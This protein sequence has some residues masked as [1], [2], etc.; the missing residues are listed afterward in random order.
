MSDYLALDIGGANIKVADGASYVRSEPF[1]LWKHPENLAGTLARVIA[2]GPDR[3]RIV[4]T[5]TG[6]LADCYA[7]KCE[8]VRAIVTALLEAASGRPTSV[9]RTD[10][11][12]ID[13]DAALED[14]LPCAASNWHALARWAGRFVPS[15]PAMLLDTGST[16]C[17]AIPL[18]DGRVV[19]KGSTD[20]ERLLAGE[21]AYTGVT[22]TPV[23]AAVGAL[24]YRGQMC[25]VAAEWFAT[26]RDAYLWLDEL[27]EMPEC[28]ETADGRP[29]TKSAALDRLARCICADRETF[30]EE[31]A[32]AAAQAVTQA[33]GATIGIAMRRAAAVLGAT[34]ERVVISG[35]GEFLARRVVH[36]LRWPAEVISL[37]EQQ[38]EKISAAGAAHAVAILAGET[39]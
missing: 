2:D 13:A 26:T 1:A 3:P 7:T 25:P 23:C 19:A 5:M 36:Q 35:Q 20:T 38:G 34:P 33:Q 9:Y 12:F 28:T 16:T 39:Q 15:G 10:G 14:P 17:D 31:D 37:S 8:G 21:L 6:E 4:A 22:R 30:T 11:K 18:M 29:A 27:P 24:P 32:I